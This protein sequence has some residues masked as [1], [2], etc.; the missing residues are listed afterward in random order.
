ME[1]EKKLI[2]ILRN[3][4]I[5]LQIKGENIFKAS[6]Y[7]NAA[8]IIEAMQL[9]IAEL[10]RN[11]KLGEIKGFGEAL[12]KK[13]TEFVET[14]KIS[15]Y[16]KLIQEVPIELVSITK[17]PG[18][19]PKKTK[20]LFE[21]LGI[22]SIDDLENACLE[23]KVANIKGFS[24]TTQ[25]IILNNI[26]HIKAWKG[27]KQQFACF[28]EA[29]NINNLLKSAPG[30][31]EHSIVGEMRRYSE[32][33]SN[34]HF[35]V[36]TTEPNKVAKF[37]QEKFNLKYNNNSVS[38]YTEEEVSVTINFTEP[39]NFV[40]QLHN[41]TGNKNYIE[42]FANLFQ[43]R[44]GNPFDFY[45]FPLENIILKREQQLFE[46]LNIQYIPPE[47]REN[48]LSIF[49]AK[50]WKIP[51]LIKE[52]DLRGMIHVHSNW[53]D[54]FNTIEQLAIAAK[55]LGFEYI[56]IC[57]HSQT[58]KYANG[59]EPERVDQQHKEIDELNKKNLGIKILKGIESDI[60]ADGS[61]DYDENTLKK[62]DLVVAS[63]HSHFKMTKSE[64]TR[65]LVYAI[66]SPYTHILGHPTGRLL[67]SRESYEVD[68][69]E[70][71]DAAA[72]YGKIIE[73]NANPYRLDL[74][75]E[76]LIYAKEKGVKIS[77]NPDSHDINSLTDI[78]YGVNFLRKGW[79]ESSDVV[80]CLEH[81]E[82]VRFINSIGKS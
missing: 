69:K 66:M 57:D 65:R 17:I 1:L 42:H 22:K 18:I 82:F 40:W 30:V 12:V 8:D 64:M 52:K 44:T 33:I 25:E 80:N 81:D 2:K 58:A 51:V 24:K 62:F 53:S 55:N 34:I 68:I 13:I 61:L 79:L 11:G 49:K 5:L 9:D 38:F 43:E 3:I 7:S 67:L 60:L 72:D 32:I 28:Q 45:Q 20:T 37:L 26:Q 29:N 77:I 70:I 76:H 39:K 23:G 54:G 31:I 59:L 4:S 6:A 48:S 10:V 16:E 74:P 75:W 71:I 63:V 47:L 15:F 21:Q 27:K 41:F 50:E 46:L 36:S 14:G 19:G 56:V 73:F 78:F 35:L